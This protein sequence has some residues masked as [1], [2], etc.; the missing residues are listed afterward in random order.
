MPIGVNF[1]GGIFVD[2]YF[3]KTLARLLA[4]LSISTYSY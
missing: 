2:S 3:A 1:F 4:T